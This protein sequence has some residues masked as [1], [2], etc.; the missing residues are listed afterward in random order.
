MYISYKNNNININNFASIRTE[1]MIKNSS[2][3]MPIAPRHRQS[4]YSLTIAFVSAKGFVFYN[5]F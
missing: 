5:A 1:Q 4:L 2:T 3:V